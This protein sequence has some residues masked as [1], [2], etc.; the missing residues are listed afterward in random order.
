EITLIDVTQAEDAIDA[1]MAVVLPQLTPGGDD[2]RVIEEADG[3]GPDDAPRFG[4]LGVLVADRQLA[5]AADGLAAGR[6]GATAAILGGA[7]APPGPRRSS[8]RTATQRE[9]ST[10]ASISSIENISG[11]SM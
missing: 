1:K 6:R 7:E 4:A 5:L 9:P 3:E 8:A 10:S 2:A 11:G